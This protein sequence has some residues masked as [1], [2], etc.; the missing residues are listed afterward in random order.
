MAGLLAAL[1]RARWD[2][3]TRRSIP[4][5][6]ISVPC[7]DKPSSSRW[8]RRCQAIPFPRDLKSLSGRGQG[9]A[10][11]GT[12]LG[13]IVTNNHVVEGRTALA[14]TFYDDTIVS[15]KVVGTDPE[16]DL[17]VVKVDVAG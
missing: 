6:S 1:W 12:P 3:F 2:R 15:A 9:R 4:P 5:S 13:H 17:A 10:L 7:N 11:C 14:V 16:S 8:C